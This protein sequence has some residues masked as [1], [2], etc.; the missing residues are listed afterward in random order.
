MRTLSQIL[1]AVQ[2]AGAYAKST[3]LA[4]EVSARQAAVSSIISNTD[5]AALDSFSEAVAEM[6]AIRTAMQDADSDIEAAVLALSNSATAAVA[7]VQADLDAYKTSN[8]AAVA[9]VVSDL[10]DEVTRAQSA[11]ATLTT[12]VGIINEILDEASPA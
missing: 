5:P 10:A 7:D 9:D 8:D 12:N 6:N 1:A 2:S 3:E 11:E 4:S